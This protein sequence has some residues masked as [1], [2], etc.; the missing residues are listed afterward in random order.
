MKRRKDTRRR[1]VFFG[2]DRYASFALGRAHEVGSSFA[3]AD[4]FVGSRGLAESV[5]PDIDASVLSLSGEIPEQVETVRNALTDPSFREPWN[6]P[7]FPMELQEYV[8]QLVTQGEVFIRL[9]F[10]RLSPD[11]P[12]LLSDTAWLAP[13]TMLFREHAG[14]Y[15]QFASRRAFAGSGYIV[16]DEPRDQLFEI[17]AADVL[18][19]RWPFETEAPAREALALGKEVARNAEKTLL[20]ARARAEPQEMFL[21]MARARDGAF[22]DALEAQKSLSA[23]IKDGLYYPG[24]YEARFFPWVDE[25]TGYFS[26]DRMLRSRVAICHLREYLFRELNRQLLDRWSELNDWGQIELS[27]RPELFDETDWLRMREELDSGEIDDYDV[28]AA[29]EIEYE[30]GHAFGRF[31]EAISGSESS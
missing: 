4:L 15:E 31:S 27:L 16:T 1:S 2:T 25:I 9:T 19:L 10:D 18:H 3:D 8:K 21:P 13:E 24:A 17:S 22:G 14:V 6:Q 20:S 26:A 5:I 30:A 11:E 12:Y 28:A 7:T 23:R 29:I